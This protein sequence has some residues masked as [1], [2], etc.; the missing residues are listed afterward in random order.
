MLNENNNDEDQGMTLGHVQSQS[1]LL[2]LSHRAMTSEQLVQYILNH[3]SIEEEHVTIL[4]LSHNNLTIVPNLLADVFPNIQS[5]N[6]SHNII[7]VNNDLIYNVIS[8]FSKLENIELDLLPDLENGNEQENAGIVQMKEQCLKE[9]VPS[10]KTVNSGGHLGTQERGKVERPVQLIATESDVIEQ[11][12]QYYLDLYGKLKKESN[13][14]GQYELS[15]DH[16][17]IRNALEVNLPHCSSNK[18]KSMIRQAK[19]RLFSTYLRE[20]VKEKREEDTELAEQI[21]RAFQPHETIFSNYQLNNHGNSSNQLHLN[22]SSLHMLENDDLNTPE[23]GIDLEQR[24]HNFAN[25][26]EP[27]KA[28]IEPK[29]ELS[30]PFHLKFYRFISKFIPIIEWVPQ[31]RHHLWDLKNDVLAGLTVG[32]M[33]IPQSMAYSLVVGLPPVYGLYTALIPLLVYSVLG[34]SRQLAVGPTAMT[35]LLVSTSLNNLSL[36]LIPGSKLY[37]AYALMFSLFCGGIQIL[38][39]LCRLGFLVNFLSHP[40]L[41]GF[42]SAAAVMIAGSQLTHLLGVSLPKGSQLHSIIWNTAKAV[43]RI[44][45]P[46]VLIGIGCMALLLF[47]DRFYFTLNREMKV[48]IWRREINLGKRVSLKRIPAALV[49]VIISILL[50][51]IIARASNSDSTHNTVFGIRIVGH[52]PSSLPSPSV[53]KVG[54]MSWQMLREVILLCL[55]VALMGFVEAI[56]ISKFYALQRG[57]DI[58]PNQELIALG[59]SN[60]LGGFFRAFPASGSIS[61]TAVNANSKAATPLAGIISFL[62]VLLT[63]LLL[64]PLFY[65]LPMAALAAIIIYSCFKIPDVEEAIF[66]FKTKKR[67]FLLMMLTL[68]CT[69]FIGITQGILI[70][71]SASLVM[72]IYRSSR[73]RFR[74]LGRQPGTS[75]YRES[76][77]SR[78][79]VIEYPGVI[80]ARFEAD[81]Y[82]AN[83]GYFKDRVKRFI[84]RSK[85]PVHVF[86]LDCAGINQ[87]DSTAIEAM[88]EIQPILAKQDIEFYLAQVKPSI[89]E[90][91][92][93]GG[94]S[95]FISAFFEDLHDAVVQADA[96]TKENV[97]FAATQKAKADTSNDHVEPTSTSIDIASSMSNTASSSVLDQSPSANHTSIEM[98]EIAKDNTNS[99]I[100]L[101]SISSSVP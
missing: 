6:L 10:L 42:T 68:A 76:K 16:A 86:V 35:S 50:L 91:L 97:S 4:D 81:M 67:D 32:V 49:V 87:V 85:Y 51:F 56:S 89:R 74:L 44:H 53:P 9:A 7:D 92:D 48:K 63:L 72:V 54:G 28:V 100:E 96:K 13:S 24:R 25:E 79:P 5:L 11:V 39:G 83:V 78:L 29:E 45:Y 2:D 17:R 12:Y 64:T 21:Q 57:Y 15:R 22:T 52:I 61:R 26:S 1:P 37:I 41:S 40:V 73:P 30:I 19:H 69:L 98:I 14:N 60:L 36:D 65:Y 33:L 8:R 59:M 80:V 88:K 18:Y 62:L 43:P 75:M 90:V 93:R 99:S 71:A 94:A 82:F 47:L 58:D 46:T 66:T 23:I 3:L 27:P 77:S 34:T 20:L 101:D 95:H 31:Y 70:G 55:P 38:L 84:R